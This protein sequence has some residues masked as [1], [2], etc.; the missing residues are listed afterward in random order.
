MFRL[1]FSF[2]ANFMLF[3]ETILFDVTINIRTKSSFLL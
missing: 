3:V 2:N 1:V